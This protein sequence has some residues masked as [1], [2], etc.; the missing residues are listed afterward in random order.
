VIVY[1]DLEWVQRLPRRPLCSHQWINPEE[2]P[3]ARRPYSPWIGPRRHEMK[4]ATQ[5]VCMNCK[6]VLWT[7]HP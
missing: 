7:P 2:P 6:A 1:D 4:P 5:Y 3:I